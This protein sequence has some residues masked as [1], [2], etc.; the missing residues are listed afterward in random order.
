MQEIQIRGEMIR[1][2]QLLKLADLAGSGA[3]ARDL[4]LENGVT[5]NGELESRRGRQ[6]HRG[7][8]VAVGEHAVRV[9]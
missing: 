6:L 5:V 7:D 3:D 1:L 8:V 2:G 9:A 4:L